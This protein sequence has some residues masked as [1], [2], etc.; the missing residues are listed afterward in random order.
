MFRLTVV[1]KVIEEM[2]IMKI[3]NGKD[4]KKHVVFYEKFILKCLNI[5]HLFTFES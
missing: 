1:Q 2:I 5:I 4:R 3:D